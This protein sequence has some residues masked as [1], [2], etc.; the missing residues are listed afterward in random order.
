M[1]G[2]D[3]K[4][5]LLHG[6]GIEDLEKYWF[7]CEVVWFVKQV[8]DDDI[9][10]GQLATTFSGCGQPHSVEIPSPIDNCQSSSTMLEV[11]A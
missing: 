11:H 2:D 5:P 10:K 3:V 7:F 8:Q 6:N 9:K 1:V 4:L